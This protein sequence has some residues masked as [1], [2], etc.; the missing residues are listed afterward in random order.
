MRRPFS[1]V[2]RWPLVAPA[3]STE[4]RTSCR[5]VAASLGLLLLGVAASLEPGLAFGA[6]TA[7]TIAGVLPVAWALAA[8]RRRP[9]P[10]GAWIEADATGLV[11]ASADGK[12][13]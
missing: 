6:R 3:G 9:A 12:K 4:R 5:L 8:G 2:P 11:R 7:I 10:S 1:T 13:P